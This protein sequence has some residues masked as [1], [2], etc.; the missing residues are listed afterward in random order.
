MTGQLTIENIKSGDKYFIHD[1][2]SVSWF[3]YVSKHPVNQ[4]YHIVLDKN[5]Q[6]LSI[7]QNKLEQ[8]LKLSKPSYESAALHLALC[9]SQ[10]ADELYLRHC[11]SDADKDSLTF[12]KRAFLDGFM[13]AI[14]NVIAI[15]AG[16]VEAVAILNTISKEFSNEQ[17]IASAKRL[18]N[19][20]D[21]FFEL[22]KY[23]EK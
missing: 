20:N 4:N 1:N 3:T 8:D 15:K 2:S 13:T 7:W 16:L 5:Q 17:I 14:F 21:I 9:M 23:R 22:L 10:Q 11:K 19:N 18:D 6:P 12:T